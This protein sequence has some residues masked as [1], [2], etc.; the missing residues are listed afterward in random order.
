M[1]KLIIG[2]FI[3][4][5]FGCNSTTTTKIGDSIPKKITLEDSSKH[6]DSSKRSIIASSINGKVKPI[7]VDSLKIMRDSL[8]KIQK[9]LAD[10]NIMIVDTDTLVNKSL[11][12]MPEDA[13]VGGNSIRSRSRKMIIYNKRLYTRR[14]AN[15]GYGKW[16]YWVTDASNASFR[17]IT[18]RD[19]KK[20]QE[21]T[22]DVK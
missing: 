14:P 10:R 2:L 20:G 18:D 13:V 6:S 11:T 5:A 16:E 12:E 3:T 21:I 22:F 19:L 17:Y 8:D 7:T 1:K 4:F 9:N 15:L